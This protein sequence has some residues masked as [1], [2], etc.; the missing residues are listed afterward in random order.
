MATVRKL[1][2]LIDEQDLE[3]CKELYYEDAGGYMGS[4]D[5]SSHLKISFHLFK[6]ITLI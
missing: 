6:C 1:Y 4:S 3:A 5:E 2:K